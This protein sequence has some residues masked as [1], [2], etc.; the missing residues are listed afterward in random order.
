LQLLVKRAI[1]HIK[2]MGEEEFEFCGEH[3]PLVRSSEVSANACGPQHSHHHLPLSLKAA[4]ALGHVFNDIA[5][6]MWFSYMLL[7]LQMVIGMTAELSGAMLLV[8]EC[9]WYHLE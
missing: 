7:F 6:A 1:Q 3:T 8:G 2:E 4:Y 9:R 5:A